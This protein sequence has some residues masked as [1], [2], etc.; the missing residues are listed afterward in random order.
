MDMQITMPTVLG[1][2]VIKQKFWI[3]L[4]LSINLHV[5]IAAFFGLL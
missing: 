5:I 1:E 3:P 4:C 2:D